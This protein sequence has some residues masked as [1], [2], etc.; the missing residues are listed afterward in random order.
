MSADLPKENLTK[1]TFSGFAWQYTSFIAQAL[2]QLI[3][4]AVLAR[5]LSPEDFG[6]L[7]LAMIF[8]GFAALF[9]Q[10]G[11]GPALIQ[12]SELTPVH[13]RVGFTLSVI[14][15]LVF[16]LLLVAISP[17]VARFVRNDQV[18]DVL[19]VVSLNFFFTGFGVVAE[20]LLKRNLRF[21]SLMWA[22]VWSYVF[23]YALTGIVL[24][25]L[26][27][28]V[29]ALVG[30]TLGQSLLKSV[31]LLIFNPHSVLPSLARR[32]MK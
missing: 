2:L 1:K 21:K 11:V 29:W 17:L 19:L 22:S 3:V 4:L 15:S 7:G 14:L 9:S 26:G 32:E 12:R 6:V 18:T 8:V 25:Y 28:G 24:A 16:T 13:I 20:S 5:L 30:A 27:F 23:G 10:L 31:L